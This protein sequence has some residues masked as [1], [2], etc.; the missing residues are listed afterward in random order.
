MPGARV[1]IEEFALVCGAVLALHLVDTT[2]LPQWRAG[3]AGVGMFV[4]AM[5]ISWSGKVIVATMAALP[6]GPRGGRST[7]TP[8]RTG[9]GDLPYKAHSSKMPLAVGYTSLLAVATFVGYTLESVV[10][11]LERALVGL[12]IGGIVSAAVMGVA[13]RITKLAEARQPASQDP[14]AVTTLA[15]SIVGIGLIVA[16]WA[17][18][19]YMFESQELGVWESY[20]I[21]ASALALVTLMLSMTARDHHVDG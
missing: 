3:L 16:A 6:L 8:E 20:L 7:S 4:V 2:D 9:R 15:G 19:G 18:A 10:G 17:L 21:S 14:T 5:H 13:A 11:V 12:G 1:G